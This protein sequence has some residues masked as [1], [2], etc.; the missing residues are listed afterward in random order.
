MT[1]RSGKPDQ[2]LLIPD[3]D[4]VYIAGYAQDDWRLHPRLT[5]NFGLRYEI[6]TDVKNIS[7]VDELNPLVVPF[8]N[9]PRHRDANN[10]APRIGFNWASSDARLSVRGGYGIYYDRVTLEIRSLGAALTVGRCDPRSGPATCSSSI[11]RPAGAAVCAQHLEPVHRLILPGAGAS[12]INIIDSDMQNP[13]VRQTIDRPREASTGD[14]T[15]RSSDR[16]A[17]PRH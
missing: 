12:G 17:Q 10:W 15:G 11:L 5:L 7:R 8:A 3:A 2:D 13:M 6:D 4:N 1:L 9:L 14:A 16:R